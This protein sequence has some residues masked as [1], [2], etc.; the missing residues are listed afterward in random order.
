MIGAITLAAGG[1]V[2][3][4]CTTHETRIVQTPAIVGAAPGSTSTVVRTNRADP[5]V[6]ESEEQRDIIVNVD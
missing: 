6:I 5:V 4:A 1:L 3:S 2:I